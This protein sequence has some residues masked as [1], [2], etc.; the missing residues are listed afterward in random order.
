MVG[1]VCDP[2]CAQ[3]TT[4]SEPATIVLSEPVACP[5]GRFFDRARIEVASVGP[6]RRV[7]LV[8]GGAV[9]G[10]GPP[11]D[12]GRGGR[13]A[14]TA[15]RASWRRARGTSGTS[16]GRAGRRAR[17]SACARRAGRRR[18]RRACRS[19]TRTGRRASARARAARGRRAPGR[20]CRAPSR[21]RCRRARRPRA[22]TARVSCGHRDAG[23]G[24]ADA[25]D[26]RL[27]VGGDGERAAGR[28]RGEV[29]AEASARAS[30]ARS[31]CRAR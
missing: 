22:A 13:G 2:N 23:A 16:T 27:G 19:P 8:A 3:G 20:A 25:V 1:L 29:L 5:A 17:R 14:R 30:R 28:E 12:G 15:G 26:G 7:D 9:L 10:S 6:G 24:A 21:R 4:I 31:R 18:P 11:R